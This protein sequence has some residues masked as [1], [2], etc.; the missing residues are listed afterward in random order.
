MISR[1]GRR[2]WLCAAACHDGAAPAGVA[3]VDAGDQRV[4]TL[5]LARQGLFQHLDD[6]ARRQQRK[7][8]LVGSPLFGDEQHGE[9]H[10]GDVVVPGEPAL[11]LIV[12]ETTLA[13]GVVPHP[14][15][16]TMG[17]LTRRA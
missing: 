8:W 9:H 12:G 5:R 11:H 4:L 2:F 13:F 17:W 3:L 14:A 15:L 7:S 16:W 1:A 6:V 10:H